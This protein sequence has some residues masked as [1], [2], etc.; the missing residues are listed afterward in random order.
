MMTPS[1]RGS[2][3]PRGFRLCSHLLQLAPDFVSVDPSP[4]YGPV[5]RLCASNTMG[6]AVGRS[7]FLS[8]AISIISLLLVSPLGSAPTRIF[9]VATDSAVGN[10]SLGMPGSQDVIR[11]PFGKYLAVYVDS[12]GNLSTAF[13]NSNPV[14]PGAWGIPVKSPSPLVAYRRPATVLTTP[15]TMRVLAERSEERRVGKEG[16]DRSAR[17]V[18]KDR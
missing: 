9:Q 3:C 15:L 2:P 7:A 16:E 6:H 13:A 1:P 12:Q 10:N 17:E 4:K 5:P 8:I 18:D 11:D 14:S